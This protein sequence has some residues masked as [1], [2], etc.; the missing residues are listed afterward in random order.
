MVLRVVM[1]IASLGVIYCD[2]HKGFVPWKP[3]RLSPRMMI[4]QRGSKSQ[5]CIHFFC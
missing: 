1:G 5:Q 4:N 3:E 2:L